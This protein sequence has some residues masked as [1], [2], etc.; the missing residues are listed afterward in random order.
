MTKE[1]LEKSKRLLRSGL[2]PAS[3]LDVIKSDFGDEICLVI[4]KDLVNIQQSERVQKR[5]TDGTGRSWRDLSVDDARFQTRVDGD[6]HLTHRL[7]IPPTVPEPSKTEGR[8]P[9]V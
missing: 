3:V 6:R 8:T 4:E 2:K 1:Q 9:V 5:W 7:I